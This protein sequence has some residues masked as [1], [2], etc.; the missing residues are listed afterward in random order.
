MREASASLLQAHVAQRSAL[1][2]SAKRTYMNQH[3]IR[4]HLLSKDIRTNACDGASGG[5]SSSLVGQACQCREADAMVSIH[6]YLQERILMNPLASY[7]PSLY[8]YSALNLPTTRGQDHSLPSTYF[9]LYT[10]HRRPHRYPSLFPPL[11]HAIPAVYTQ[12]TD[13]KSRRNTSARNLS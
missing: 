9:C 7:L 5:I 11:S 8:S 13:C 2:S 12:Q 6:N 1:S 3:R 10:R 4:E